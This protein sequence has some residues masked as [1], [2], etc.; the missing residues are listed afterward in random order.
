M[1]FSSFIEGIENNPCR[2]L[3]KKGEEGLMVDSVAMADL[4][5]NITSVRFKNIR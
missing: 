2:V 4:I 1:P 5:T 3:V